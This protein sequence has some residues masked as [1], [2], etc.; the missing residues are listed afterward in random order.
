ML[1]YAH[2][3]YIERERE[4]EDNALQRKVWAQCVRLAALRHANAAIST[5]L[6]DCR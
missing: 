2:Y 1:Y 3:I 6:H 4:R 5:W